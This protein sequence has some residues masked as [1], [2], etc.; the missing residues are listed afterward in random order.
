MNAELQLNPVGAPM[1]VEPM[2][3]L[4]FTSLFNPGRGVI[5]PCDASGHV[6]IDSLPERLRTIYFGARAMIGREYAYPTV[7]PLH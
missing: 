1:H 4:R 6:D 5:V 2:H 3:V 7:E